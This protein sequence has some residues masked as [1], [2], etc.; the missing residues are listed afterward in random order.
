MDGHPQGLLST[1]A[2]CFIAF[3]ILTYFFLI[4]SPLIQFMIWN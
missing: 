2:E 1:E 4:S 3:E